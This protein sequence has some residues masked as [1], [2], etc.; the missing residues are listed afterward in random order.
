MIS[1]IILTK[2][3]EKNISQCLESL[4]WCDEIIV[5]DD[6]S[7]DKT[8]KIASSLGAEVYIHPLNNNFATQRNYGLSKTYG[9]WI[10]FVDADEKISPSLRDEI[11]SEIRRHRRASPGAGNPKSEIVGFEIKRIDYVWNKELRHGE[12]GVVKLLRLARKNAGTWERK[13]HEVWNINDPTKALKNPLLHYPHQ[14][15]SEFLKH[16]D[17]YSTLHA[18][19]KYLDGEKSSLLKIIIWPKFKF[20][21]NWLFLRGF[22]DGASGLLVAMMMSFHSFLAWS[23]LWLMRNRN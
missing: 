21:K 12:T 18:E 16:I 13:V 4:S 8:A 15:L 22:L 23:K 11:K 17:F 10:L 5:I 9:D 6:L 1:A 2:D 7:T 3:E 20:I 19:Q 14:N